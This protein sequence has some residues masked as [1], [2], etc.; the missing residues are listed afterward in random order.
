MSVS[1]RSK[2]IGEIKKKKKKKVNVG[3]AWAIKTLTD[4]L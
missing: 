3:P 1:V 2:E 4:E